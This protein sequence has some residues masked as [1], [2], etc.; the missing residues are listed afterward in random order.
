MHTFPEST[1]AWTREQYEEDHLGLQGDEEEDKW[2][3]TDY[4]D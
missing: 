1:A 3:Y 2:E 4:P